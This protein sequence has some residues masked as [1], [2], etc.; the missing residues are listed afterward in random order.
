MP[1]S[2]SHDHNRALEC[3]IVPHGTRAD[4]RVL[5]VT[6]LRCPQHERRVAQALQVLLAPGTG[7]EA[8]PGVVQ[9]DAEKV[10]NGVASA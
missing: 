7:A 3:H 1:A 9:D 6:Y 5:R 2:L 10:P 4:W 8:R